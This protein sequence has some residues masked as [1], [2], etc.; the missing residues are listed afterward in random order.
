MDGEEGEI[1]LLVAMKK[2]KMNTGRCSSLGDRGA[3]KS[4]RSMAMSPAN[5]RRFGSI[6][7]RMR[8]I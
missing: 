8:L 1:H 7:R 5:P 2:A 4:C 6:V 3:K